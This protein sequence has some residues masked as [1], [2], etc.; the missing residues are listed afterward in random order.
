MVGGDTGI[1]KLALVKV[2]LAYY[3]IISVKA[4]CRNPEGEGNQMIHKMLKFAGLSCALWLAIPGVAA[5]SPKKVSPESIELAIDKEHTSVQFSIA[6]LVVSRVQGRFDIAEGKLTFDASKSV[7][8]I[9]GK[10]SAASINTNNEKRDKHLRSA[11]FF[12]V[13]KFP[14]LEFKAE[15]LNIKKGQTKKAKA[16]LTIRGIEKQVMVDVSNKGALKDPWGTEKLLVEA[17]AAIN[18]KDF[19][20]MWNEALEAGGVMVGDKVTIEVVT[21]VSMP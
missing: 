5:E 13:E 9:A 7:T 3:D 10:V 21:Q 6:H 2:H 1:F 14:S 19:G 4:N 18:R 12:D 16:L 11:D 20:L 8:G 17:K 15:N